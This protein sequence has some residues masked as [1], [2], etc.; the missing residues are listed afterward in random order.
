MTSDI[1]NNYLQ[2]PSSDNHYIIC[3]PEFGLEHVV[4]VALIFRDIYG[5]KS[6]G[7]DLWN[8][9]RSCMTHIGFE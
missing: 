4:K 1:N 6:S 7:S 2:D 5:G 3:S 9:W 8:H